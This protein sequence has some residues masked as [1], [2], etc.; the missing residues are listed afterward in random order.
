MSLQGRT[1]LRPPAESEG[2]SAAAALRRPEEV[3]DATAP[4]PTVRPS[5]RLRST[6]STAAA[7]G[8][9]PPI[10]DEE[11]ALTFVPGHPAAS[12]VVLF[13]KA[14]FWMIDLARQETSSRLV[15]STRVKVLREEGKSHGEIEIPHS[16]AVR[17]GSSKA[18]R[19]CPTAASCRCLP[20]HASS[21]GSPRPK[22]G[23]QP[24]S[25]SPAS[26]WERPRLPLRAALRRLHAARALVP[27]REGAGAAG[28]NRLPRAGRARRAIV[29]T[30]PLQAGVETAT[31]RVAGGARVRVWA[32][33]LPPGPDEPFALPDPDL[34]T[35]TL[36][37]PPSIS[38]ESP[39]FP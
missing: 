32:D 38:T 20:R 36:S 34:A 2:F 25:P 9:F 33:D 24:R 18:E 11:K 21:G 22:S 7:G 26:R 6:V 16:R 15:V 30:G 12:A 5:R 23:S 13:K 17:G 19:C 37:C 1:S 8:E 14:E 27:V 35:R 28:G 39:G 10:T 3:P 29:G 4:P 31:E